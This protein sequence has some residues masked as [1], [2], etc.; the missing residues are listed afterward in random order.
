LVL[1]DF[2]THVEWKMYGD[3]WSGVT[4]GFLYRWRLV[5]IWILIVAL[6]SR[7]ESFPCQ[8]SL[9]FSVSIFTARHY[10]GF[11]VSTCLKLVDCRF[12]FSA[13]KSKYRVGM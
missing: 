7:M 8:L 10:A 6:R 3:S 11:L 12:A 1:G 4:R 9:F 13:T 5:R 2:G